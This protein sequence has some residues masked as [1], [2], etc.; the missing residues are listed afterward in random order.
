MCVR[1][2]E[3]SVVNTNVICSLNYLGVRKSNYLSVRGSE[4]QGS[5]A[6]LQRCLILYL[7]SETLHGLGPCVLDS[8]FFFFF[9]NLI[10]AYLFG[11][12]RT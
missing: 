3:G 2:W 10:F 7:V 9:F 11:C 8:Q 12:A 5:V 4:F 1:G 6:C